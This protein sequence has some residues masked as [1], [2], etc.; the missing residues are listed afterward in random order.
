MKVIVS[1]GSVVPCWCMGN[2]G[3]SR[4][5]ALFRDG[6]GRDADITGK[7]FKYAVNSCWSQFYSWFLRHVPTNYPWVS[8]DGEERE[9]GKFSVKEV[10]KNHIN[11]PRNHVNSLRNLFTV[12]KCPLTISWR[13]IL[14][15]LQ[16]TTLNCIRAR[17]TREARFYHPRS[18]NQ[19]KRCCTVQVFVQLVSQW[20]C[21]TSCWQK[22]HSFTAQR[23]RGLLNFLKEVTSASATTTS[24]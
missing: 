9:T 7:N 2:I 3:S 20:C 24:H 12:V 1:T 4:P 8:G 6:K 5:W 22:V 17:A 21:E 13:P 23:I 11:I 15:A 16:T 14:F 10:D 18:T 19:M